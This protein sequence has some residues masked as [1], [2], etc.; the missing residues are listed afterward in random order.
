VTAPLVVVTGT[1]TG[2]GKTHVTAALITAWARLLREAGVD[3]PHVAGLKPVET[4]VGGAVATDAMTLEQASTFHVKRFPP[5]YMLTRAVSPHLAALD[6]GRTI[7]A[8]LIRAYVAEV[9]E[10]TDAVAVELAGG[11][12]SPL[13]RRLSNADVA[14]ILEPNAV[15]LIVPDRLGVLHDVAATTRAA[16]ACGVA[17]TGIVVVAP[18]HPDA[19]TGTNAVELAVVTELPVLATLPRADVATLSARDDLT[20]ILS[21]LVRKRPPSRRLP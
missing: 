6:E 14:A 16:R 10:V 13:G 17:F 15:L 18:E 5:P 3:R 8:E 9:R 7:D 4:G 21:D 19:S 11:L 2:I 12:F 1:G 20:A